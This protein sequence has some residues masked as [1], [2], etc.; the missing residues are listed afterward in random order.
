MYV[1]AAG[2]GQTLKPIVDMPIG[3]KSKP[4][5]RNSRSSFG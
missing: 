5:I 1:D 4:A 2:E 3:S